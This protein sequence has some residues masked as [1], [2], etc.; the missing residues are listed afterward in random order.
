MI[1]CP[2]CH[3]NVMAGSL[4]CSECGAKLITGA[5]L[6]TQSI[7]KG[8]SDIL[9]NPPKP[10][11]SPLQDP[12]NKSGAYISLHLL[13]SGQIL[14]LVGRTEFT[15]GRVGER[16]PILPDIDL[17]PYDAYVQGVSRLHALL[18]ISDQVVI[19]TDLG[20]SNGTRV[21]GQKIL[22]HIDYPLNHGDVV[23]LGKLK[24]QILIHK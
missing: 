14:N 3:K 8:T 5:H 12:D 13:E 18:K 11:S 9:G 7:P 4:F 16:Q 23:A 10:Q 22:P 15:L 17:S 6:T 21:N 19:V 24:I 2:N 20:S 1:V